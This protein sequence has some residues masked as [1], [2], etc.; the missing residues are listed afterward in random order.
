MR[1]FLF[2]LMV[3]A[4]PAA[5]QS[6]PLLGANSGSFVALSVADID[7]MT[8]WYRDTLGFTVYN[9]GQAPN[10]P[11]I[12]FALLH[13]GNSILEII[14]LPDAKPFVEVAPGRAGP[15]LVHGSFKIGFVVEQV[16]S[17]YA[18]FQRQGREFAFQ[19][20]QLDGPY[21]AFGIRDPEGNLVQFFGR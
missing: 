17:V 8:T 9:Q 21:R 13:Q 7:R 16:D 20:S 15:W 1:S 6:T 12:R 14:R 3:A 18:H 5:A 2:F 10:N 19:L 4:T 11:Q